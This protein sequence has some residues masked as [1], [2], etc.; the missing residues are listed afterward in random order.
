MVEHTDRNGFVIQPLEDRTLF[1]GL[2]VIA[3]GIEP[4]G[5]RPAWLDTMSDA[6]VARAGAD[7]AVYS[8]LV[9][10]TEDPEFFDLTLEWLDGTAVAEGDN[11]EV[12]LLIDWADVSDPETTD[13]TVSD[14]GFF[15][16]EY[17]FETDEELGIDFPWAELPIHLI[18]HGRGAGVVSELAWYLGNA[19]VWVDHLTL[20]DAPDADLYLNDQP[21]AVYDNALFADAYYQANAGQAGTPVA[22][23]ANYDLSATVMSHPGMLVWYLNTITSPGDGIGYD[24]SRLANGERNPLGVGENFTP[25]GL[26]LREPTERIDAQ[27]ANVGLVTLTD[28]DGTI[29]QGDSLSFEFLFQDFDSDGEVE[30]YLDA[31][32]NP[33]NDNAIFLAAG[34]CQSAGDEV[35]VFA[36]TVSTTDVPAGTYRLFVFVTD[37]DGHVRYGYAGTPLTVLAPPDP[38]DAFEDNDTRSAAHDLGPQSAIAAH[39]HLNLTGGDKDWFRFKI[40]NAADRRHVIK[41]N[42]KD[43]LGRLNLNLYDASGRLLRSGVHAPNKELISLARLPKGAY[44][45]RVT[46]DVHPKYKLTIDAPAATSLSSPA[47]GSP[48]TGI[49]RRFPFT[50]SLF[51][52]ER[53]IVSAT[54]GVL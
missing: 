54:Q 22:G 35:N 6:I 30:Y 10:P 40:G 32:T 49:R 11:A 38:G 28:S 33:Y 14:I 25:D 21:V 13:T 46:G 9:A 20:L 41:V 17:L 51:N 53:R 50:F 23:A 3:H 4:E 43:A 18:G 36:A 2:T 16:S 39:G 42:Y 52:S 8:L 7:T 5:A 26:G 15:V 19:G 47:P 29:T 45:A 27:Y 1:A 34:V 48:T 12:I 37:A 24:F 31:D 44:Y